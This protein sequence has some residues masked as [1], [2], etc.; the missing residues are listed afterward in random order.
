[1][2]RSTF[3]WILTNIRDDF[4]HYNCGVLPV[5]FLWLKIFL[6]VTL[7]FLYFSCQEL[8]GR[9]IGVKE[10]KSARF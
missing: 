8:K 6:Q 5:S 2:F 3:I 9:I 10:A 7:S 4:I 1:M